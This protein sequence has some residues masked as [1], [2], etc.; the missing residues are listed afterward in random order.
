[1]CVRAASIFVRSANLVGLSCVYVC[2]YVCFLARLC[3]C[4]CV[5]CLLA[6]LLKSVC[7]AL[8]S[9][10]AGWLQVALN[11]I[12]CKGAV[13][14]PGAKNKRQVSPAC[15]VLSSGCRHQVQAAI[16]MSDVFCSVGVKQK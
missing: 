6:W 10:L 3:V 7:C 9:A 5:A 14:I 16:P 4:E 13:P 2:M 8:R 15:W 11:W 12:I 1:M